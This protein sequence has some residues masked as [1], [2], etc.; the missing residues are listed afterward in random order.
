[1]RTLLD[2]GHAKEAPLTQ[3]YKTEIKGEALKNS[4]WPP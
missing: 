3:G 2:F 4:K 1:M